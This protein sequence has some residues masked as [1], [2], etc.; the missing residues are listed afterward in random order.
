MGIRSSAAASSSEADRSLVGREPAILARLRSLGAGASGAPARLSARFETLTGRWSALSTIVAMLGVSILCFNWAYLALAPAAVA[1]AAEI[2]GFVLFVRAQPPREAP[3]AGLMAAC[4]AVAL[5]L[6]LLGGEGHLFFATDDWIVRDAVL[7]DLVHAPWPI[8]YDVG[9]RIDLLRAPLGMYLAPALMGKIAGEGIAADAM[10]AQNALLLGLILSLIA[11]AAAARSRLTVVAVFLLFSGMDIFPYLLPKAATP[12]T[13]QLT[14]LDAWSPLF[15]FSSHVTQLFWAPHHA[16]AGWAFAAAYLRWRA[17]RLSATGLAVVF[18][19]CLFWSPLAGMGSLPFLAWAGWR[20]LV[21][22]RLS[23]A[24]VL[25]PLLVLVGLA[26][27]LV[28]LASDSA[29]VEHRWL[30]FS[31]GFSIGY[32]ELILFE[33]APFLAFVALRTPAATANRADLALTAASLLALPLYAISFSND[34]TMRASIPA[35]ALLAVMVGRGVAQKIETGF[36]GGGAWIV[37]VLLLGA[38][39]PS[40]EIARAIDLPSAAASACN[41]VDG[42][43]ASPFGPLPM[44][45]YLADAGAFRDARLWR[46]AATVLS[47]RGDA[48]APNDT[49][50]LVFARPR[51]G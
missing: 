17:Q 36:R 37:P 27:L 1:S 49:R 47:P 19:V 12:P 38:I 7:H 9:G 20:D 22:G 13:L 29:G 35:L 21:E 31:P 50:A 33:A 8:A 40:V 5:V 3:A 43:R 14:H 44:T 23:A 41:L 24:A 46:P 26:P 39:T 42:W 4:L 51:R 30:V 10:L 32:A 45:A 16:L 25:P 34:F 18:L 6:C 2:A 15:Q 48:C 28:Y 11:R